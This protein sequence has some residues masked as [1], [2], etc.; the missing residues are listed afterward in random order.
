MKSTHFLRAA[1][2][3][4]KI[5]GLASYN[6][7]FK[8]GELVAEA[9][10]ASTSLAICL[11]IVFNCLFG[12]SMFRYIFHPPENQS[13]DETTLL[14]V[15]KLDSL[16]CLLRNLIISI[17]AIVHRKAVVRLIN[18]VHLISV[19][20]KQITHFD[21]FLDGKCLHMVR[22]QVLVMSFQHVLSILSAYLHNRNY[23]PNRMYEFFRVV[24]MTL[25]ANCFEITVSTI[26][27]TGFLIVVQLFRHINYQLVEC[28]TRIRTISQEKRS[29]SMRMQMFCDLSDRIDE[30]A[31]LYR[32]VTECNQRICK[33]FSSSMLMVLSISFVLILFGVK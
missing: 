13:E 28:V 31:A 9:T 11:A 3:A 16:A 4:A 15:V 6:L 32:H 24:T 8:N 33:V 30:I 12:W 27:F 14:I 29:S 18:D 10:N 5:N 17:S 23:G 20:I 7:S 21:H 19:Q 26:H 22:V 2:I 25:F 1:Y